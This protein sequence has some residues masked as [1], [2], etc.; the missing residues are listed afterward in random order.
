MSSL[1][2]SKTFPVRQESTT[3]NSMSNTINNTGFIR[4]GWECPKCGAILAP[5]QTFCPFCAPRPN[6]VNDPFV[7]ASPTVD[8]ITGFDNIAVSNKQ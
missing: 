2:N 1:S 7:Y 6:T 4:Q 3:G 8:P 5:D